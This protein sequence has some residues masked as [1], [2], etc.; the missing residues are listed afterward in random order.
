MY[1]CDSPDDY[2]FMLIAGVLQLILIGNLN[3]SIF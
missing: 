1:F 3:P 2:S